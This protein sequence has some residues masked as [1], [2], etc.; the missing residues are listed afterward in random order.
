[1]KSIQMDR[2]DYVRHLTEENKPKRDAIGTKAERWAELE[3]ERMDKRP[4][5]S[6]CFPVMVRVR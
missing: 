6:P 2:D 5:L 1:M 3:A 4:D